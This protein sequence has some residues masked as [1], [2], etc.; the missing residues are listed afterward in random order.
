MAIITFI[1]RRCA[2][3][4]VEVAPLF[5]SSLHALG[6]KTE[7]LVNLPQNVEIHAR[8][9]PLLRGYMLSKLLQVIE[10]FVK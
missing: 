9:S 2:G 8:C 6:A 10:A 7:N 5:A 3:T 1:A 4:P